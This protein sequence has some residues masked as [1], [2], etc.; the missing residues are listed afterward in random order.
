MSEQKQEGSD[1]A[2]IGWVFIGGVVAVVLW[3]V[4][5]N[6]EYEIKGL[7]RWTRWLEMKL[8]GLVMGPDYEL[9]YNGQNYNYANV[10]EYAQNID[11]QNISNEA[12]GVINYFA[13][14]PLQIPF[15]VILAACAVWAVFKGPRSYY[16]RKLDLEYLIKVQSKIFP[17][18]KPFVTFDPSKQPTRPPGAP[19]PAE[20]PP[21]A[22]ALGPEEWL[23]YY[24]IP[25]P[26]GKIDRDAARQA[27]SLQLGGRWTGPFKLK[28]YKQ[29]LLAAF[30]LKATRKRKESDDMLGRLASCWTIEKGLRLRTDRKLLKDAQ[31][32]LKDKE[33]AAKA[34]T[35]ANQHAFQ[36][37]ALMRALVTAREEGG[38]LSP[39]QFVWLRAYDRTLWYPLNNLGRQA[40]HMEGL[41]AMAHFKAEKMTMRPIPKAKVEDAIDSV[42]NYMES[43][44]ARPVPKL[45]YSK[46]KSRGIKKVKKTSKPQKSQF[47]QG[48]AANHAT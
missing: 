6:Y 32:V 37:T 15:I 33:I 23:A 35:N 5:Y 1:D 34:L 45:D 16:R 11:Y 40:F 48:K 17:V 19:V 31:A 10:I 14:T 7:V 26:D 22:E 18:V 36:T 12:L 39:S 4:W 46:S 47:S 44:R 29:I 25:I 42:I 24:Q 41:G 9:V 2:A 8:V 38:V 3:L 21:F 43:D 27:F 13:M 20:L 30:C 28:P